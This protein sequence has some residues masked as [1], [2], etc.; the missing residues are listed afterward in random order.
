MNLEEV[1]KRLAVVGGGY[2]GIELGQAFAKF[3]TKVTILEAEPP[4][5]PALTNV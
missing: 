1:P 2:I 4:S 3:G 5:C